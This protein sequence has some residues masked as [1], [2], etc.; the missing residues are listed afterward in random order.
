[1][2]HDKSMELSKHETDVLL[3]LYSGCE[4][5]WNTK[6]PDYKEKKIRIGAIRTIINGMRLETGKEY[7]T[8]QMQTALDTIYKK[9]SQELK[10]VMEEESTPG[11]SYKSSWRWFHFLDSFLRDNVLHAQTQGLEADSGRQESGA[12]NEDDGDGNDTDDYYCATLDS[13]EE[14]SQPSASK[15]RAQMQVLPTQPRS[16]ATSSRPVRASSRRLDVLSTLMNGSSHGAGLRAADSHGGRKRRREAGVSPAGGSRS[17]LTGAAGASGGSVSF[18]RQGGGSA[19][20]SRSAKSAAGQPVL[21]E[22]PQ[23]S[24]TDSLRISSQIADTL[25]AVQ[26]LLATSLTDQDQPAMVFARHI[27]NELQQITDYGQRKQCMLD[28]QQTILRYQTKQQP[29]TQAHIKFE[30]RGEQSEDEEMTTSVVDSGSGSRA[31][32]TTTTTRQQCAE[33]PLLLYFD[34]P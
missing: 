8:S 5:L 17:S 30:G 32:T 20:H 34:T 7:S 10:Q 25:K 21:T 23:R 9:Y 22:S 2:A 18:S 4:C 26:I 31:A 3:G 24:Q 13:G 33:E 16:S 11:S 15:G 28:I 1:M 14:D 12:V 19:S 29:T 6:N 27:A